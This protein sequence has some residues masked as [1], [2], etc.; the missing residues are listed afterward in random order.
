M[1]SSWQRFEVGPSAGC[2]YRSRRP[3]LRLRGL[4][5]GKEQTMYRHI[6]SSMVVLVASAFLLIAPE[7]ADA[8]TTT[9]VKEVAPPGS[10]PYS[11]TFS[12][13]VVSGSGTN[14]FSPD[15]IPA[16]KRLVIEFV[17]IVV[18]LD[19]GETP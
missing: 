14:G 2:Y 19:V 16:R 6:V 11:T 4:L 13:S 7:R 12:I 1:E 9:P 5:A 8:Q 10:T 18:I 17:S 15:A 3:S